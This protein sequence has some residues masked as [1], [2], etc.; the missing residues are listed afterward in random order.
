MYVKYDCDIGLLWLNFSQYNNL[1]ATETAFQGRNLNDSEYR[2]RF[3]EH[4]QTNYSIF[5]LYL[6]IHYFPFLWFIYD[7]SNVDKFPSDIQKLHHKTHYIQYCMSAL[8][9]TIS[10]GQGSFCQ[11]LWFAFIWILHHEGFFFFFAHAG[12]H[13]N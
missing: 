9:S 10:S 6:F 5:L 13:A 12:A 7:L 2:C 1:S 3:E 11:N 4:F 8:K